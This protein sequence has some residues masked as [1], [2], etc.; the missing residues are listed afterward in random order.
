M[1]T[2]VGL[3][4]GVDSS[5]T[6]ALLAREPG[7]TVALALKLTEHR[8]EAA[9]QGRA[10][11]STDDLL[12]ARRVAAM[13]GIRCYVLNALEQFENEVV[14]P[15][16]Q[17]YADG[18]TPNPCV[19]CNEKLK[20]GVLLD[21]ALALGADTL[22]TGHYA[23]IEKRGDRYALLRARDLTKDQSYFLHHLTQAQLAHVRFPLGDLTKEEVRAMAR[24]LGL[25]TAEKPDSQDVCFVGSAGAAA[26]VESRGAAPSAGEVVDMDGHVVGEHRGVHAFTP[27]QRRGLGVTGPQPLY[28]ASIDGAA[29][30]VVVGTREEASRG[31]F[32]V[33]QARWIIGAPPKDVFDCIAR[34]RYR[35]GG[36]GARVTVIGTSARVELSESQLGIAP[37]QACVFYDGEE[38]LGGGVIAR[39]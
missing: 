34:P 27:G 35:H 21:Q 38:V 28:V 6:A 1:R 18:F 5:V 26:Y 36:V 23:R 33:E 2:V 39:G 9:A 15:F 3:S 32:G 20:F 22:A 12:D 29:R 8:A 14:Q 13:L 25:M 16:V 24:E 7:E 37:G 4:G 31:A 11:C 10:C 30:R 17:G 19:T